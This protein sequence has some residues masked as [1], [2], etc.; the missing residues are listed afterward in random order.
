MIPI[1]SGY[2]TEDVEAAVSAAKGQL[3]SPVFG[4]R[5][6]APPVRKEGAAVADTG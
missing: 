3:S 4:Q 2:A 1:S 5:A 6:G